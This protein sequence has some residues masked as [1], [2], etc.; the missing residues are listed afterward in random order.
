MLRKYL[1]TFTNPWNS[2]WVWYKLR[3]RF[4]STPFS[5]KRTLPP[6]PGKISG[7]SCR[8]LHFLHCI[9]SP[10]YFATHKAGVHCV[11]LPMVTQLAEMAQK[12]ENEQTLPPMEEVSSCLPAIDDLTDSVSLS[13]GV[14]GRAPDLHPDVI[15]GQ[16]VTDSRSHSRSSPHEAAGLD[17][18]LQ[19]RTAQY[20][21]ASLWNSASSLLG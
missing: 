21:A 1:S 13:V 17:S 3:T 4:S 10:R 7:L 18:R 5:C 6:Q 9:I 2:S 14:R 20:F 8:N 16:S 19:A 15:S 12:P 11:G